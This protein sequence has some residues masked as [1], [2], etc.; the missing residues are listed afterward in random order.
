MTAASQP[1]LDDEH[2]LMVYR[3]E[4]TPR[5]VSVGATILKLSAQG[6]RLRTALAAAVKRRER[7]TERE[8]VAYNLFSASFFDSSPDA[9]LILLVMAVESLLHPADRSAA[10]RSHVARLIET[11]HA[12]T[13]LD[14]QERDSL[15]GS[16]R[17]L[18]KESITASGTELVRATLGDRTYGEESAAGFGRVRTLCG[19][20]SFTVRYHG[21][22]VMQW[23]GAQQILRSWSRTYCQA[24]SVTSTSNNRMNPHAILR[25]RGTSKQPKRSAKWKRGSLR[26]GSAAGASGTPW[27]PA[28]RRL[29]RTCG[30]S[31]ARWHRERYGVAVGGSNEPF[32]VS[33]WLGRRACSP[34]ARA[35]RGAVRRGSRR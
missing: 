8:E 14:A 35:L 6:A 4:P 1:V 32:E 26:L 34:R 27:R 11:T 3:T 16:L 19:A 12:S 24:R 20:S 29:G 23:D 31:L 7:V 28:G 33:R 2:G 9:R 18:Q 21:P 13:E 17:W 30:S 15:V 10:A 5:F 25:V 22:P